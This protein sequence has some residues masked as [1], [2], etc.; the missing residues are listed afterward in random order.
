MGYMKRLESKNSA[1]VA[2]VIRA[3]DPSKDVYLADIPCN[4]VAEH[5]VGLQIELTS[6]A[7]VYLHRCQMKWWCRIRRADERLDIASQAIDDYR[8]F[9]TPA[10]E[11]DVPWK[12]QDAGLVLG[13]TR[14][15]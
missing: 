1:I 15:D 2:S 10:F 13:N 12:P 4:L 3:V 6:G 8:L 7:Q 5:H 11:L 9:Q 14:F